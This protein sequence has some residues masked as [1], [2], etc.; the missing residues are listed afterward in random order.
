MRRWLRTHGPACSNSCRQIG[1]AATLVMLQ[2]SAPATEPIAWI[3]APSQPL[4]RLPLSRSQTPAPA[5][6]VSRFFRVWLPVQAAPGSRSTVRTAAILC[7]CPG[8]RWI[9]A[10]RILPAST[11]RNCLHSPSPRSC[12]RAAPSLHGFHTTVVSECSFRNRI[13]RF[14]FASSR[15]TS[16]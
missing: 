2:P 3:H 13:R 15:S 6:R 8:A 12:K 9:A 1:K 4:M 5:R 10:S 7:S 14:L 16:F 11:Q